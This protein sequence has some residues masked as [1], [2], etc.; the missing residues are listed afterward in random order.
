MT[1]QPQQL[2]FGDRVQDS[3]GKQQFIFFRSY[4]LCCAVASEDGRNIENFGGE[5]NG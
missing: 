1:Q 5:N 3:E 2:K 4:L